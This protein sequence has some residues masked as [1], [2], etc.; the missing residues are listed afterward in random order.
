[1]VEAQK[2]NRETNKKNNQNEEGESHV[3]LFHLRG[4]T[5][6]R[7]T[8]ARAIA[9][10]VS[11]STPPTPEHCLLP[12]AAPGRGECSRTMAGIGFACSKGEGK[13]RGREKYIYI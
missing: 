13:R 9:A 1:M 11:P 12:S 10:G 5:V 4:Q 7:G 6:P 3:R 8:V 2:T